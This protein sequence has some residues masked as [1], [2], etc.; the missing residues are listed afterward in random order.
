MQRRL[1]CSIF[2]YIKSCFNCL[3]TIEPDITVSFFQPSTT[4][5]VRRVKMVEHVS[6]LSI[7]IHVRAPLDMTESTVKRVRVFYFLCLADFRSCCAD[8]GR[9]CVRAFIIAFW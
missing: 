4:A 9:Y 7:L 5:R 6:R 1:F 8:T 3:S 2:F